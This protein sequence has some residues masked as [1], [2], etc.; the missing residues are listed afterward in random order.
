MH[1]KKAKEF[2]PEIAQELS[3][4]EEI[5]KDVINTYWSEIRKTLSGVQHS[6]V[7][8]TNLGDFVTKHWKIDEKIETLEKWEELNKLKGMQQITARFKVA[9]NLYD[10][11]NLK[12]MV[13][14]EQQRKEFIKL[15]KT[16]SNESK[17]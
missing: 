14:E 9:E 1:P 2:I 4:Q 3:I 10:L 17:K 5:V 12:K 11:R 13:E 8:V 7:H 6:R 15:H 16:K